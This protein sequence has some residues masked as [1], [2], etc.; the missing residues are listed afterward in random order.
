MAASRASQEVVYLHRLLNNLGF[1]QSNPTIVYGNN[2]AAIWWS[3]FPVGFKRARHI[4]TQKHF[5]NEKVKE[6]ALPHFQLL[7]I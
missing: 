2:E 6:L 3:E 7:N 1:T 4:D 5:V